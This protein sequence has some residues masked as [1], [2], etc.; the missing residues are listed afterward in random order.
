VTLEADGAPDGICFAVEDTG[1]GIPAEDLPHVFDRYWEKHDLS[2]GH[3]TGPGLTIVKG[4][5]EVHGGEVRV[6]STLG[7]RSRFSFTIPAAR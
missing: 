2:R 1:T 6:E 4:I 3:G 7:E 5:V